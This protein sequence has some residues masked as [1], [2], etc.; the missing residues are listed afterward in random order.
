MFVRYVVDKNQVH[1]NNEFEK[2]IK[3]IE[4]KDE[5]IKEL[6]S[7]LFSLI[8]EYLQYTDIACHCDDEEYED[9]YKCPYCYAQEVLNNK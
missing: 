9:Y 3:I 8:N 7:A 1:M 6:E 2:F 5:R 4:R